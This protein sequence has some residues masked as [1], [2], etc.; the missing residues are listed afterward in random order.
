M[1]VTLRFDIPEILEVMMR[2]HH[3]GSAG[4]YEMVSKQIDDAG[5]LEIVIK[6]T[7]PDDKKSEHRE[8]VRKMRAVK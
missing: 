1:E 7:P 8:Y 3:L 4:E 5:K 2:L 6:K